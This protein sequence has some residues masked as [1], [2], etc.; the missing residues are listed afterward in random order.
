MSNTNCQINWVTNTIATVIPK[1]PIGHCPRCNLHKPTPPP[2]PAS[3]PIPPIEHSTNSSKSTHAQVT[4]NNGLQEYPPPTHHKH[5]IRGVGVPKNKPILSSPNSQARTRKIWT[6]V[7][8][9][10]S[11]KPFVPYPTK[12]SRWVC[13]DLLLTQ[14][15]YKGNTKLYG[16]L[17]K[18][19][20]KP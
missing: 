12:T 2:T 16:Y 5:Q 15:Y 7:P 13:K 19:H 3:L 4:T 14:G 1:C 9:S 8:T 6:R 11:N 10:S 20:Y 17:N 18:I